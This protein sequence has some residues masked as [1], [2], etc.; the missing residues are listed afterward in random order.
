VASQYDFVHWEDTVAGA[1]SVAAH[2]ANDE[3]LIIICISWVHACVDTKFGIRSASTWTLW[4]MARCGLPGTQ[5]LLLT[6]SLV[7][8]GNRFLPM[9]P[10]P[11]YAVFFLSLADNFSYT[12]VFARTM[13]ARSQT[14][15]PFHTFVMLTS[16][17]YV[18]LALSALVSARP[19]ALQDSGRPS[20]EKTFSLADLEGLTRNQKDCSGREVDEVGKYFHESSVSTCYFTLQSRNQPCPGSSS[21]Y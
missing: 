12:V 7:S 15:F 11:P 4:M 10:L 19:P 5:G 9:G 8:G 21:W 17:F 2:V 16:L 3:S 13:S 18:C 14:Q 1:A 6:F 20:A